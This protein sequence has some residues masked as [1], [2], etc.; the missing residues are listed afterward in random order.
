M[1]QKLL[2][3]FL[4]VLLLAGFVGTSLAATPPLPF[5]TEVTPISV[6][7][8]E[9]VEGAWGGAA[10]AASVGAAVGGIQY[11]IT[12]PYDDWSWGEGIRHT[13][14]GAVAGLMGYWF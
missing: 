5:G 8:L 9:E 7:E 4:V 1:K 12:T 6:E 11:L 2:S 13:L 3:T 14:S 10:L